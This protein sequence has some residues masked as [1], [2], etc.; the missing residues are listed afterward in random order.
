[1]TSE[2][3]KVLRLSREL[4]QRAGEHLLSYRGKDNFSVE[5]KTS[6]DLVTSAD[7]E[8]EE[9]IISGIKEFFPDDA[10]LSEESSPLI[11]KTH[12][13]NHPLWI[14]DPIDGTTNFARQHHQFGISI[15]FMIEKKVEVG[16]VN[17]P[18]QGELFSAQR[19]KGAFLNQTRIQIRRCTELKEAVI[20][21][22]RPFKREEQAEF[23]R[24]A[25]LVLHNCLDL[26]RIGAASVDLCWVAC[27]RL[28]GFFET[29]NPWD[30]AAGS[31][32][33]REAGAEVGTMDGTAS[34]QKL[35]LDLYAEKLLAAGPDL[36]EKLL[37]LL[38]NS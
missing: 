28:D 34:E 9:I 22:G 36:Y 12:D 2:I 3:N 21:M 29:L 27:G 1:M 23:I 11:S 31:L 7:L 14:I 13:F 32:I 38:I 35:P 5:Y 17:S 37:K 20:G 19:G 15:A 6:R 30:I 24:Q 18:F 4:A 8:A 16:V 26:R 33:A 25:D 10:I